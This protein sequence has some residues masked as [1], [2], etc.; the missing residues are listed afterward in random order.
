MAAHP[1]AQPNSAP[2]PPPA[3]PAFVP[4][5]STRDWLY[6]LPLPPGCTSQPEP[7]TPDDW[8]LVEQYRLLVS[9]LVVL[10]EYE[11][12]RQRREQRGE[13]PFATAWDPRTCSNPVVLAAVDSLVKDA[14]L[15]SDPAS[16]RTSSLHP[17]AA[18]TPETD[19]AYLGALSAVQAALGGSAAGVLRPRGS[20]PSAA[21][22]ASSSRAPHHAHPH[23]SRPQPRSASSSSGSAAATAFHDD[24]STSATSSIA[25]APSFRL[26]PATGDMI[27]SLPLS[28]SDLASLPSHAAL[29][30][31]GHGG[32]AG[33]DLAHLDPSQIHPD[34]ILADHLP[35]D[36]SGP[37]S[38]P[39]LMGAIAELEQCVARLSLEANE[40]RT[41][42]KTLRMEMAA[43]TGG[44]GAGAGAG[45]AS[46]PGAARAAAKKKKRKA[47]KR[48]AAE[49]SAAAAAAAAASSGASHEH[50]HEHD[51]EPD[52]ELDD[53]H[54]HAP[55]TRDEALVSGLS[56]RADD[57]CSECGESHA[58]A[59]PPPPAPQHAPASVIAGSAHRAVGVGAWEDGELMKALQSVSQLDR[60]ADEYRERLRVLKEQIH[61]HAALA[62]S[63]A[64]AP[65]STNGHGVGARGALVQGRLAGEGVAEGLW[66]VDAEGAGEGEGDMYELDE[67]EEEEEEMSDEADE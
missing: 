41:L 7:Q 62:D 46:A 54:L 59:P 15:D 12:E 24:Y 1:P 5:A 55:L 50:E 44:A 8:A 38:L 10:G 17:A 67:E 47:K 13:D 22:T 53:E 23:H 3:H 18:S 6:S 21:T 20:S 61:H 48:A 40:A 35:L 56:G 4:S 25:G 51:D 26:D 14:S 11:R 28:L 31:G 16:A 49:A 66:P 65:P 32:G 30:G 34:G 43:R 37:A 29:N 63:L 19:A 60:R 39:S 27:A 9:G 52:D 42:Q 64:A 2:S 58:S 36:L 33:L 57:C 45:G